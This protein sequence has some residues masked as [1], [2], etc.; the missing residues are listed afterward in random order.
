M[1]LKIKKTEYS[2]KEK[3]VLIWD[4]TCGF[5]KFWIIR[6]QITTK[7]NI[8]YLPYQDAADRYKDI[9]V[10]EFKKASR[11]IE[12]NGKVFSGPDSF[13]RSLKYTSIKSPWHNWYQNSKWFSKSSDHTYIF[14]AKNRALLFKLTKVCF[15]KNPTNLKHYWLIYLAILVFVVIIALHTLSQ[16]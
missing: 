5:C 9:P 6:L 11:L 3:P 10:K 2:P 13:Y 14:I 7:D 4:G 8:A 16:H 15:G 12:P 1:F